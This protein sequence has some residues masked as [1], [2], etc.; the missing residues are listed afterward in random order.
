MV[1]S[2]ARRAV[3]LDLQPRASRV[4][5]DEQAATLWM[6]LADGRT[7]GVPTAWF[8]TIEEASPEQR[9]SVKVERDGYAL[10]WDR[11]DEDI[12]VPHLLG[13]AY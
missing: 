6:E 10:R 3:T 12:A 2:P 5:V 8:P 9:A 11:L 13:L 4:W 7:L 1:S